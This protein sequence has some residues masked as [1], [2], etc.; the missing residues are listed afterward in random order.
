MNTCFKHF[1]LFIKEFNLVEAKEFAPIQP[2]VDYVEQTLKE[3]DKKLAARE[4]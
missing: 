4:E 3:L 1:Y 2:Q